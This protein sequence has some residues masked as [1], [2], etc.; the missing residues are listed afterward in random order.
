MFVAASIWMLTESLKNGKY[1]DAGF[2]LCGVGLGAAG[3]MGLAARLQERLGAACALLGYLL[4]CVGTAVMLI[5]ADSLNQIV[6]GSGRNRAPLW[7]FAILVYGGPIVG[8]IAILVQRVRKRRARSDSRDE[9]TPDI[10]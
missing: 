2:A 7:I 9:Q 10:A 4:I 1:V 8:G 3:F 5:H 6:G